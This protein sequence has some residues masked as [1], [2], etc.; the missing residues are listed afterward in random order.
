MASTSAKVRRLAA[1]RGS[2]DQVSPVMGAAGRGS[3]DE[4]SGLLMSPVTASGR[5]SRVSDCR[6]WGGASWRWVSSR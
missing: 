1:R 3:A 6:S 2:G 5:L 4:R